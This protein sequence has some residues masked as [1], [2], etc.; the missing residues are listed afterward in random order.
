MKISRSSVMGCRYFQGAPGRTRTCNLRIRSPLLYPVELRALAEALCAPR[1][2]EGN[3]TPITSLEGWGSTVELHP[4]VRSCQGLRSGREDLNLRPPAPKAGALPGC[5][6]PRRNSRPSIAERS[7]PQTTAAGAT[8]SISSSRN[9]LPSAANSTGS[10]LHT[11]VA[12]PWSS[13]SSGRR[14]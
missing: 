1:A 2:G 5:A 4:R 12:F 8:A 9:L 6:T 14:R 10:A 3:R 13:G 11:Y 7:Q